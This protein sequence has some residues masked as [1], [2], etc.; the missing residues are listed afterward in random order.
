MTLSKKGE[1]ILGLMIKNN[2][3][4][5]TVKSMATILK[6]SP[7]TV[8]NY[9]KEVA[10]YCQANHYDYHAVRGRGI[11]L[12]LDNQEL[13][14]ISESVNLSLLKD[15]DQR[16]FYIL[17]TLLMGWNTYS[18]RLFAEELY[19]STSLIRNDLES[20]KYILDSLDIQL[21]RF[22]DGRLSVA[23]SELKIRSALVKF[24]RILDTPIE[25]L[26]LLR[27]DFRISQEDFCRCTMIYGSSGV[28]LA[29][30]TIHQFEEKTE[31]AFIDYCFTMMV[32]YLCVMLLRFKNGNPLLEKPLAVK[33]A[34]NS[35]VELFM[36]LFWKNCGMETLREPLE[37]YYIMLLL[38]ASE[39]QNGYKIKAYAITEEAINLLVQSYLASAGSIYRYGDRSKVIEDFIYGSMLR[40]RY[41][42]EIINP[43]LQEIKNDNPTTFISCAALESQYIKLTGTI[44]SEHE[45]SILTL[46]AS[47]ALK[48]EVKKLQCILVQAGGLFC[49]EMIAKKIQESVYGLSVIAIVSPREL[50][51][52]VGV[53]Y[54]F[55]ITTIKDFECDSPLVNISPI[56]SEGDLIKINQCCDHLLYSQAEP[57]HKQRFIDYF[58][59]EF[60]YLDIDVDSKEK[61]ICKVSHILE[62]RGY[63]RSDY[64]KEILHREELNTTE[65]DSGIAM[66]HGIEN[67]VIQPIVVIVRL[68]NK[69]IWSMNEVDIVFYLALNFTDIQMTRYFFK[70]F[71]NKIM[72]TAIINGIRMAKNQTEVLRLMEN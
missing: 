4:P 68:K 39:F 53:N 49:A 66:P 44:P 31:L 42:L 38:S 51:N 59:A 71:Y 13:K 64:Y 63:V 25:T 2:R 18:A 19:V 33:A 36:G 35:K 5:M 3:K 11:W 67:S 6:I 22:K 29:I 20:V 43:Y 69:M 70:C 24:N 27:P 7:R 34:V 65:F 23:G 30:K 37:Q 58:D 40:C 60:I 54:Q 56:V 50:K 57:R 15:R 10:E 28:T 16:V 9:L 14:R 26:T 41:G 8:N 1:Q 45:L 55:I 72:D 17:R 12:E 61:L 32:E 62:Q 52:L 48:K 46:Y 47:G 21:I